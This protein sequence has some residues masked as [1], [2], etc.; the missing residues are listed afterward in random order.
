MSIGHS[1]DEKAVMHKKAWGRRVG[2]K[3]RA[4]TY[5]GSFK[6]MNNTKP[7]SIALSRHT[8]TPEI[9]AAI[10]TY[11]GEVAGLKESAISFTQE[12]IP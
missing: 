6:L 11:W 10:S 7:Q 3:V 2:C 4:G 1:P 8:K 12:R 5:V 9:V